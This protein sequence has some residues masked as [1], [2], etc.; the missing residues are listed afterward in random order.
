MYIHTGYTYTKLAHMH[1]CTH[2]HINAGTYEFHPEIV[3]VA[4]FH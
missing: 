2:T 1:L 3:L 4:A